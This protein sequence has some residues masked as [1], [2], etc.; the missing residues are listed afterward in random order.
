VSRRGHAADRRVR[1][2]VPIEDPQAPGCCSICGVPT[3]AKNKRHLDELPAVDPDITA[4]E[5]RR[6]GEHD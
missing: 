6:Y 2:H 5:A 3:A 1:A 4:A